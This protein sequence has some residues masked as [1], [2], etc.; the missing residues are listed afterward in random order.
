MYANG[1]WNDYT[2]QNVDVGF[3]GEF[4]KTPA[5]TSTP[6]PSNT[7]NATQKPQATNRPQSTKK[8]QA[9]K[10][11]SSQNDD[12]DYNWSSDDASNDDVTVK[13]VTGVKVKKAAKK[14]SYRNLAVV[15]FTG[16]I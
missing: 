9:T 13:K 15:C 4:D 11:P 10:K 12:A 2:G 1:K 6:A 3:I 7:P 8:P 14:E 16:W 5:A